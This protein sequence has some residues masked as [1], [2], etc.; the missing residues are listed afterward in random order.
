MGIGEETDKSETTAMAQR[1]RCELVVQG[2][3]R[4]AIAMREK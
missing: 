1:I 2:A 4:S 3:V